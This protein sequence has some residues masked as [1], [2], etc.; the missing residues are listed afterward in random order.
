MWRSV[1]AALVLLVA[2]WAVAPALAQHSDLGRI[3]KRLLDLVNQQRSLNAQR[4]LV[5]DQRL[6]RIAQAH[7][8]NMARLDFFDHQAPD[9]SQVADRAVRA[10]YPWRLIGEN[11]AAGPASES[12]VVYGWMIRPEHR[13]NILVG[14]YT[15]LG[16]GYATPSPEAGQTRFA[17]YWVAVFG[18]P[19]R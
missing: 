13:E 19:A 4:P 1:V 15:Q 14:D 16:V 12:G 17:H 10:G 8:E 6:H 3:Q 11:L 5:L 9:G 2:A 18:A 7:A